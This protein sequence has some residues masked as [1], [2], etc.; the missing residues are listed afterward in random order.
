MDSYAVNVTMSACCIVILI[1]LIISQ[2]SRHMED[3][4]NRIF[5][6]LLAMFLSIS[7]CELTAWITEGHSGIMHI[8]QIISNDCAFIFG[9]AFYAVFF[10]Y[11]YIDASGSKIL[12]GIPAFLYYSTIALSAG[13]I[14]A[15]IVNHFVPV[16]YTISADHIW[17]PKAGAVIFSDARVLLQQILLMI[18]VLVQRDLDITFRRRIAFYGLLTISASVFDIVFYYSALVYPATVFELLLIYLNFQLFTENELKETEIKITK[19]RFDMI[20]SRLRPAFVFDIL[21]EIE[22][23]CSSDPEE[24][25]WAIN[26][27]SEYLRSNVDRVD[28]DEM[29]M[30]DQELQH[31]RHYMNLVNMRYPDIRVRCEN[32]RSFFRIPARLLMTAVE[33]GVITCREEH[34]EDGTVNIRVFEKDGSVITEVVSPARISGFSMEEALRV[35]NSMNDAVKSIRGASLIIFTDKDRYTHTL[36]KMP[37]EQAMKGSVLS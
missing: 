18:L 33:Q 21:D 9:A 6:V 35:F 15:T 2:V 7:V 23:L 36:L 22:E 3:R 24:A 31:I 17:V 11:L 27:L 1:T 13:T 26:E 12:K 8:L 16:L 4:Q 37:A 29:I 25:Q 34:I 20:T 28:A 30:F 5:L 14:I 32:V 19:N 10:E